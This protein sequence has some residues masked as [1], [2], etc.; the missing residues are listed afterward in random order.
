MASIT[1]PPSTSWDYAPAP[2]SF[3]PEIAAEHGLFIG[4]AFVKPKSGKFM[5]VINPA[6]EETLTRVGEAGKADVAAAVEAATKAQRKWAKLPGKERAKY[7]F[8]IARRLQER[9]R[10]FAVLETLNNGKPIKESRDAD[11]PESAKHFFHHAGWCDK[12]R[13]AMPGG[14]EAQPVGV[15]GQIIPWNFP[16]MMAAWKIAP[17]LACGNTCVLKPAET[18]PLTALR[19]AE[20]FQEVDLPPGVVNILTGGPDT[21]KLIAGHAGFNK[22]AFTG[23]T[24]VGKAIVK[25]CAGRPVRLTMELGGKG[26]HIVFADAAIDQAVEGTIQG[27]FFN[28]GQ[29]CCAGSRLLVEESI[30]DVFRAKLLQRMQQ[31]RVGDPMDKNTDVG[32]I[33]SA[34]QRDQI[35]RYVQI[36]LT[37]GAEVLERCSGMIP[38]KGFWC[39]PTALAGVQ[40]SHT[41]AREE[42]FGPVVALMTFRTVDEAIARA[43]DSA[44]GLSAG[45]WTEKSAKMF[46]V[47]RRLRAGVVWC[48]GFNLF[49]AASPFGGVKESGFGREGGRHGL[50]EYM[51]H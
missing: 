26:A 40:P 42:I 30:A 18:T 31:L 17:A 25:A 8:R 51:A 2:E 10:E 45:V 4:G 9:A 35:N 24:E 39:K 44:Y 13:Y 19:L 12:L 46:E 37:E 23:S 38:A 28:Q 5:K 47:A 21:G 50:L 48:N 41:V 3:R 22:I 49:D 43:N 33:N 7:L 29:V 14:G 34:Q 15:C 16:L 20:I 6:T 36:A 27:I 32:A 11:V 1:Q